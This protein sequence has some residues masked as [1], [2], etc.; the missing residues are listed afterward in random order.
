[1]ELSISPWPRMLSSFSHS[2][3]ANVQTSVSILLSFP[4]AVYNFYCGL[5]EINVVVISI[6]IQLT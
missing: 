1:V 4:L 3:T 2:I 6:I 5:V